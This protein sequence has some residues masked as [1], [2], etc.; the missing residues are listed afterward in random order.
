MTYHETIIDLIFYI[1]SNG[2]KYLKLVDSGNAYDK[3]IR[4]YHQ[5]NDNGEMVY[6]NKALMVKHYR[7]STKAWPKID[8]YS[9]IHFEHVYPLKLIKEELKNLIKNGL[10]KEN[11]KSVLDKSEIV[12]LTK[13]QSIELDKFYKDKLPED[14]T[15]RISAMN[16][17][18]RKE[19]ENNTL[20]EITLNQKR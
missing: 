5:F 20:F 14:K 11:I 10:S 7:I 13:D 8:D 4:N 16:F 3:I 2:E 1:L 19:T 15:D 12:V 17:E 9:E 18:I 6:R